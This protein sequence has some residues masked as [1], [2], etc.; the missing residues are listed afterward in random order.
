MQKITTFLMFNGNAEEALNFYLSVFPGSAIERMSRY[1]PDDAKSG[2][3][4]EGSVRHAVFSL[5]GQRFMC[6]DSVVRHRFTFTPSMSLHV[7]CETPGEVD[8][9]FAKLSEGGQLL[10]P[11]AAYPFSERY[12][13]FND[14]FGVSWQL[15]LAA[16]AAA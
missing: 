5:L 10:M 15:M 3:G 13:W 8:A 1:G 2:G 9:L 4:R 11:L 12:A 7:T 16:P 6:I 14:R